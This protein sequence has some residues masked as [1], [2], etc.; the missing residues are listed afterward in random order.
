MPLGDGVEER[1]R[2]VA[3]SFPFLPVEFYPFRV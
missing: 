1:R 3:T 2:A